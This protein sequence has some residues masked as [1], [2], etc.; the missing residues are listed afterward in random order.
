MLAYGLT[1]EEVK[2]ELEAMGNCT[3]LV[4]WAIRGAKFELNYQ[5][6]LSNAN[7]QG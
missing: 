4:L 2:R 1:Q 3:E 7:L 6:E 5:E